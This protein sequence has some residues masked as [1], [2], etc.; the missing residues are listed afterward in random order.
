MQTKY[1][2]SI[3]PQTNT[4]QIGNI[5]NTEQVHMTTSPEGNKAI[6]EANTRTL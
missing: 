4:M 6:K 3:S 5:S 2:Q 1:T